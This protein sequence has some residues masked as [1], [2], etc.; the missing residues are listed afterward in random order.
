MQLPFTHEQFLDLF[1]EYN[2]ALWPAVILLWFATLLAV[3]RL[4]RKHSNSSRSLVLLL[5]FHW[6]WAGAVYHIAFFRR[7][8]PVAL[9]FGIAF[10]VQ[11]ALF[12]WRGIIRSHLV[13][14]PA[15]TIWSQF[16]LALVIYSLAYPFLGLL[17]GLQYPRIPTFGVPCSTT[18]LTVGLLLL[19]P[20]RDAR[21]LGSIP[22]LWGGIG[23]SA[24]F[25][26]GV[27]ADLVLPLAGVLMLIYMLSPVRSAGHGTT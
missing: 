6:A 17:F 5:A 20:R 12:L 11:A 22:V 10:L 24:A 26:L 14:T 25:V 2:R 8:N 13:F 16:G 1:G 4:F 18:I 19:T 21:G 23:G 7:I 9:A 27:K 3:V 15:P